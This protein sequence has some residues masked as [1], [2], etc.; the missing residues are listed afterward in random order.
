MDAV[1]GALARRCAAASVAETRKALFGMYEIT[2]A[3]TE[4]KRSRKAAT[5]TVENGADELSECE[6]TDLDVDH[7]EDG[8]VDDLLSE[9]LAPPA[10]ALVTAPPLVSDV[11]VRV[12]GDD[13]GVPAPPL[14]A[15]AGVTVEAADGGV[16]APPLVSDAGVT[17]EA[18]DIGVAVEAAGGG[19]DDAGK[20]DVE[21]ADVE[22]AG[23][24]TFD[25][26]DDAGELDV[27][28]AVGGAFDG[29]E[30]AGAGDDTGT[31]DLLNTEIEEPHTPATPV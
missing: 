31:G 7:G 10:I 29:M 15:D 14:V 11:G 12:E 24:G 19:M 30:V 4:A 17:V 22:T 8:D 21:A 5:V 23:G 2:S 1:S 18:A 16:T 26:M 27:E 20:L 13:V 3:P 28:A 9:A 25:G 6:A